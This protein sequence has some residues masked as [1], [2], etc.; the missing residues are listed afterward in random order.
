MKLLQELW[1]YAKEGNGQVIALVGE[2]GIGKSRLIMQLKEISSLQ[3]EVVEYFCSPYHTNSALHPVIE[4]L[5]RTDIAETGDGTD[6]AQQKLRDKIQLPGGDW[7]NQIPW[8]AEL[9]SHSSKISSQAVTPLERKRRTLKAILWLLSTMGEFSTLLLIVE[10][11]HWIDPTSRELMQKI[12]GQISTLRI[13]LIISFRPG[14]TQAF[15]DLPQVRRV[16]LERLAKT[17]AV[18]LVKNVAGDKAVPDA[19]LDHIVERTDG[20]PLFLEELTKMALE[21][22]I[23]EEQ[24]GS[25]ILKNSLASSQALPA[26]LQESLAA[27]LDQL[28]SIK[29][30]AQIASVIGREFSYRLLSAISSLS[31]GALKNAIDQLIKAGL[32]FGNSSRAKASCSFKHAMV[33]DAAYESLLRADRRVLHERIARVLEQQTR[34]GEDLEPEL[35]AH[36]YTEAGLVSKAVQYWALATQR[37][38]ERR[39]IRR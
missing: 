12:I 34:G 32:I 4:Q 15:L 21:L 25:Y 26:T 33:R 9:L 7:E 17:E 36:H 30:I 16:T 29:Q 18:T 8:L 2:A 35:L 1:Q 5:R 39:R 28:G 23:V 6:Q 19:L 27:R 10:D 20:V 11:A 13:L 22:D 38:L 31:D 37:A 3:T 14:P 24:S